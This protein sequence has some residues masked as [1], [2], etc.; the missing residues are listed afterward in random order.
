M[1]QL[2]TNSG[3]VYDLRTRVNPS[4][5]IPYFTRIDN[6]F[7]KKSKAL[8][9]YTY[10]FEKTHSVK[11]HMASSLPLLPGSQMERAFVSLIYQ[12][13][14]L[15]KSIESNEQVIVMPLRLS[16]PSHIKEVFEIQPY[17]QQNHSGLICISRENVIGG[18]YKSSDF[19]RELIPMEMIIGKTPILTPLEY[20]STTPL[21]G[22]I[23]LILFSKK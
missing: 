19:D 10:V 16:V 17:I 5:F 23:D 9:Q 1:L 3:R 13:M 21:E 8:Y 4:V 22:H 7:Y 20:H 2:S 11:T 12:Y 6:A 14:E 18:V 15:E